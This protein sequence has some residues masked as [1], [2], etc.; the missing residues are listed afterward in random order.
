MSATG[1]SVQMVLYLTVGT[2]QADAVVRVVVTGASA[3]AQWK[4]THQLGG[5]CRHCRRRV[6]RS[7]LRRQVDRNRYGNLKRD[8]IKR[9]F[10]FLTENLFVF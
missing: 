3:R 1:T 5:G 4:R 10:L 7:Q 6:E 9:Y 2:R 8:Q